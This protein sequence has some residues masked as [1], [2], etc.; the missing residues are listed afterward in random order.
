MKAPLQLKKTLHLPKEHYSICKAANI[1]TSGNAAG[2]SHDFLDLKG[3]NAPPAPLPAG[4]TTKGVIAL[5]FSICSGVLGT[6]VIFWYSLGEEEVKGHEEDGD[7]EFD[8]GDDGN[9]E[10][11]LSGRVPDETVSLLRN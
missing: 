4:F 6:V 7:G 9:G 11:V 10:G 1:P 2:N 5:L 8:D 3:E